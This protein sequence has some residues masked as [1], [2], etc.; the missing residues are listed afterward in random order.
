LGKE[1]VVGLLLSNGA[2]PEF[3][4]GVGWT[5]LS[6]A[7][8]RGRSGII[9]QL[10]ARGAAVNYTYSLHDPDIEGHDFRFDSA[11]P[12]RRALELGDAATIAVLR[13]YG[14]EE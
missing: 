13:E 3:T 1:A 14:A 7:I 8:E 12:L 11:T 2:D 9:R 4:D 5:P 6:R 10:L